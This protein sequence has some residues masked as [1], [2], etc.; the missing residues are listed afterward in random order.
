MNHSKTF[1]SAK[2]AIS[3]NGTIRDVIARNHDT[4]RELLVR[5]AKHLGD[6]KWISSQLMFETKYLAGTEISQSMLDYKYIKNQK[7]TY[8]F[9]LG[10]RAQR[11]TITH[12]EIKD[13]HEKL[14]RDT[15]AKYPGQLRQTNTKYINGLDLN[16]PDY[17][18]LEG[19]LRD[20]ANYMTPDCTSDTLDRAFDIHYEL[21]AAQP[22]HDMNKRTARTVMNWFLIQNNCEP[23]LFNYQT[24]TSEYHTALISAVN[25][26]K[27]AYKKYMLKCMVRTQQDIIKVLQNNNKFI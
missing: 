6:V 16:I 26:D 14:A 27:K 24:D 13:I 19:L 5:Q 25:N 1:L 2:K 3:Q 10:K 12:S 15:G 7:H 8:D 9:I 22:F 21:F 23:I 18:G 11:I 20:I 4:I 17:Q